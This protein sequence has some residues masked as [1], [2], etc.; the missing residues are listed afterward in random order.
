MP[1]VDPDRVDIQQIVINDIQGRWRH[2][3]EQYGTGLQV[4]NGRDMTRDALEEAQDL[5]IYMTGVRERD[6]EIVRSLRHILDDIHADRNGR[7]ATCDVVGPCH[8]AV[9][10]DQL[11]YLLV[12]QRETS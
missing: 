6:G 5:L 12:G 11:L 7:C 4:G 10:I 8:T 1:T 2:G 9:D 3:R